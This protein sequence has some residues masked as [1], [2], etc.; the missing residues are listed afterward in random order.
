MVSRKFYI[1]PML[2]VFVL[3]FFPFFQKSQSSSDKLHYSIYSGYL[4]SQK[5]IIVSE[6]FNLA[7]KFKSMNRKTT[8]KDKLKN[9]VSKYKI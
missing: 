4:K 8:K 1:F 7:C 3:V 9:L 6:R 5:K 2:M